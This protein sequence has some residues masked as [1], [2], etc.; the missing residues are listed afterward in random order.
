MFRWRWARVSQGAI[1]VC[2]VTLATGGL[3]SA[4]ENKLVGFR[5]K[6]EGDLLSVEIGDAPLG[7]VLLEIAKRAGFEVRTRGDLG[8]VRPQAF[9]RLPLATGIQRLIGDERINLLMSYEVDDTGKKRLVEVR[10]YQA[11]ELPAGFLEQRRMLSELSR[12]RPAVGMLH[13]IGVKVVSH[14]RYVA[15][16]MAEVAVPRSLFVEILRCIDRLRG[17]PMPAT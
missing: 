17:S 2:V 3:C 8:W 15:F 5:V 6:T 16:Q 4:A 10:A 7:D 12:Y 1:L 14:S 13:K 11:G 9:E